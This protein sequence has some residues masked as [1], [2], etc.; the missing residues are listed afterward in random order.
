MHRKRILAMVMMSLLFINV[1]AYAAIEEIDASGQYT[2]G[3]GPDESISVAKERAKVDAMRQA[4]EKAGVYVESYSK[5]VNAVLTEDEVRVI[6][7]N[8]LK[9]KSEDIKPV[10]NS[11]NTITYVCDIKALVDTSKIDISTQLQNKALLN[12]NA[13]LQKEVYRLNTEI[14]NLKDQYDRAD[15][16][17]KDNLTKEFKKNEKQFSIAQLE[18]ESYKL[19]N[20]GKYQDAIEVCNKIIALTPSVNA[21]NNRGLAYSKLGFIDNAIEDYKKAIEIDA[22]ASYAYYNLALEYKNKSMYNDALD[23]LEKANSLEPNNAQYL[24]E[25]GT[26]YNDMGNYEKSLEYY[27]KAITLNLNTA[28]AYNNR[29]CTLSRMNR[30]DDAIRDYK[31]AIELDDKYPASYYNLALE[32][33]KKSMYDDALKLLEKANSLDPDNAKFSEALGSIYDVLGDVD[34]ALKYFDKSISLNSDSETIYASRAYALQ[35]NNKNREALDDINKAIDSSK[36]KLR[37]RK[38]SRMP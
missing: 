22:T 1:P 6:A 18:L 7:D 38:T 26:C 33:E 16:S 36:L 27:N 19:D 3:D 12:E 30:Q 31:K 37:T 28:L 5:T 4:T 13:K 8:V 35:E 34:N 29:G 9:V 23:L 20:S 24:E 25:I 15:I 14:E 17:K 2:I 10:I 21:Y 32:Y 11:N